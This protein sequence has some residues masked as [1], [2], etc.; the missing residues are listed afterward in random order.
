MEGQPIID[1]GKA[2]PADIR[3]WSRILRNINTF[4]RRTTTG[5]QVSPD[6]QLPTNPSHIDASRTFL[7]PP[8]MPS[9]AVESQVDAMR[10]FMPKASGE[11]PIE[12]QIDAVRTFSVPPASCIPFNDAQAVL[13]IRIFGA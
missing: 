1:F 11:T 8:P 4:V 2:V 6:T 13:A 7:P 9:P 10:V 12:S 3:N 5:F